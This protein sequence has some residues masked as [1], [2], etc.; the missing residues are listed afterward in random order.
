M[1]RAGTIGSARCVVETAR[2]AAR[3]FAR[4][5]KA[6]ER[7]IRAAAGRPARNHARAHQFNRRCRELNQ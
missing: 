3:C 2:T 5:A 4:G 1:A 7:P 6:A